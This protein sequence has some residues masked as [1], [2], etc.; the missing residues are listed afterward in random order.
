M[1]K[2]SS[3]TLYRTLYRLTNPEFSLQGV[4]PYIVNFYHLQLRLSYVV[5]KKKSFLTTLYPRNLPNL[6]DFPL[7]VSQEPSNQ[8]R[9]AIDLVVCKM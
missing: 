7:P 9:K 1:W 3:R 4:G 2:I 6:V 5:D 8:F